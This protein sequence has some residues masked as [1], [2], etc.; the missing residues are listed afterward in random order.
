MDDSFFLP[1][2]IPWKDLKGK[3]L[4]ELLYWLFDAMGAKDLEWRI[5]GSNSGT[6]DQ[7]RD[8]E[9]SFYSSTPDGELVKQRWWVEAKGRSGT[10]GPNDVKSAVLNAAGNSTVDVMV[11]ATNAAF[12]NPTRDWVKQW[13]K[14]N[15]RPKIKL[16]EKT[17]LENLC[18][19]NPVAVIRVFRHA[20]SP[21]GKLR[22]L[23]TRLWDYVTFTEDLTLNE[24]WAVK[25]R[26]LIDFRE[27]VALVASEFANGDIAVRSWGMV[28]DE[29]TL[30]RSLGNGLLNLVFLTFRIT[31]S[32]VRQEPLIRGLAYLVLISTIRNGAD[33]TADLL[34]N[35][36]NS[37]DVNFPD[38]IR[39]FVLE[40]IMRTLN[41]EIRDV[42]TSDCSRITTSNVTLSEDDVER[43]WDRLRVSKAV[44]ESPEKKRILTLEKNDG[45]CNVGFALNAEVGCPLCDQEEPHQNIP[46]VLRVIEAVAK[47]R[48]KR[49]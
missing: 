18:S 9:L 21:T 8:L 17:E 3:E 24:L 20:L 19:K 23:T 26:L 6:A 34:R 12:S 11:V 40:P 41:A 32:G 38:E 33:Y 35:V 47:F 15:P 45:K 39:D 7:G 5:G 16:W 37:T 31:E 13:Q 46:E 36:W 42:C 30:I 49:Q 1:T 4:E 48:C 10:V 14:N 28:V 29:D 43:Y 2:E 44:S 22:V 25:E 27:L